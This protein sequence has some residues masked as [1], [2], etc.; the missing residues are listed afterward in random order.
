MEE[1]IIKDLDL[2]KKFYILWDQNKKYVNTDIE[3]LIK[4]IIVLFKRHSHNEE[5][6]LLWL[7]YWF[8]YFWFIDENHEFICEKQSKYIKTLKKSFEYQQ[9]WEFKKYIDINLKM[10]NDLFLFQTTIK[11]CILSFE[12]KFLFLIEK[13]NNYHKSIWYLLPFLTYKDSPFLGFFQDVYFKKVYPNKYEKT[14]KIYIEKITKIEFPWEHVFT[15]VNNTTNLMWEAWV[16]WKTQ[17]RKKTYFSIY[18]KMIRKKWEW[19]MDTIGMRIIFED[20]EKLEKFKKEFEKKYVFI[21]K[22]DYIKCPKKNWYKSL[23]YKYISPYRDTQIMVE[24]QIRTIDMD[25]EIKNNEK[26]S[27]FQYTI[28]NK[29]W[30]K[31]FKEIHK[32]FKY[33]I[34][35]I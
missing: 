18:N 5:M 8:L 16:I 1:I 12:D 35:N 30:A 29:K 11:Y 32:W 27:H 20:L 17:I 3:L 23:H 33:T 31:L 34:K 19:V 24:L 14:K 26:I 9:N 4:N 22:K 10:D 7:L 25:F 2:Q 6:V 15:V 13:P 21:V 28:S